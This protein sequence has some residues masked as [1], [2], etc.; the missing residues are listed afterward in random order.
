V[1]YICERI[2]AHLALDATPTFVKFT[3]RKQGKEEWGA[4]E[5]LFEG[6]SQSERVIFA[7]E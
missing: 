4:W 3:G 2:G 7:L 6:E 1:R 5:L